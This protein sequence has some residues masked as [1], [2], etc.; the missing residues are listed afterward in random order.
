MKLASI[1]EAMPYLCKVIKIF[2][3]T[4]NIILSFSFKK[5]N[6]YIFQ[7]DKKSND[8]QNKEIPT[9]VNDNRD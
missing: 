8:K 1:A 3:Y 9:I 4:N 7:V 6:N 5:N 2:E